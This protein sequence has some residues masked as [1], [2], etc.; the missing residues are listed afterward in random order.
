MSQILTRPDTLVEAMSAVLRADGC[1]PE[2]AQVVAA[3]LVEASLCGHDSHGVIRILRYHLWLGS[4]QIKPR[5]ALKVLRD[6]GPLLQFDGQDG[7]GQWLAREATAAAIARTQREGLALM[8]LRRAGHIGR[9]GAY[10]E[11][12]CA[13][14]LVSLFFVNVAGSRLVAP[15]GSASRCISTAPVTIGVPNPAGGDFILDFATSLV[16]EGKAL[17]AGQ[18]GAPVPD[19]AL[20]DGE[21]RL[22]GDPRALYGDTL[23]GTFPNP[24]AGAGALRT[25]GAHKGSGLAL[26]C[27]LLGGALTGNGTNGPQDHPFGNGVFAILVDP[28][29]LESPNAFAAQVADYVTFVR[30]STPAEGVEH[31]LIPGDKERRLYAQRRRDG[32]AVPPA[33][34]D[35]L[36]A[37]S[38]ELGLSFTRDGLVMPQ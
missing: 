1:S 11:Q 31:V 32:L 30:D 21:G 26:A 12:A 5:R 17:V 16:A 15:F 4:G 23:D 13:A 7:M 37:I 8:A 9:V 14:G 38:A 36:L 33:V 28:G 18:G 20:V 3:H 29:S 6:S 25:M 35:G 22:T 10:A 19:D 27:E 34:L 24:R 2:E